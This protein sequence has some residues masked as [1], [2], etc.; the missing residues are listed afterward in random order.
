MWVIDVQGSSD[1]RW[2]GERKNVASQSMSL[3]HVLVTGWSITRH[4]LFKWCVI[5]VIQLA[6]SVNRLCVSEWKN[7]EGTI[8][9]LS[10][11]ASYTA[12][13]ETRVFLLRDAEAVFLINV[14]NLDVPGLCL[15]SVSHST[16]WRG[17]LH[18]N[19][20]RQMLI[21]W[22]TLECVHRW[23]IRVYCMYSH[24]YGDRR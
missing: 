10:R 17:V 6:L 22:E 24:D 4:T 13:P 7:G 3:Y 15:A 16:L 18:T 9:L 5:P 21:D 12:L 23:T 11:I 1:T 14:R 2:N 20:V 8:L 19:G